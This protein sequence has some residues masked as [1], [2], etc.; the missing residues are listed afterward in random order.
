MSGLWEAALATISRRHCSVGRGQPQGLLFGIRLWVAV[1]LA[2]YVAFWLELDNPSWAGTSAALVCQPVLGASLRKGW[3]R[4][5]VPTS[6]D[7]NRTRRSGYTLTLFRKEA[8][9]Q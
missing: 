6:P 1:S 3:F 2:L 5:I 8:D 9:G 4:L 7:G